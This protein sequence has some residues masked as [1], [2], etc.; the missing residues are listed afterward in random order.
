MY[1]GD[2]RTASRY[3][4]RGIETQVCSLDRKQKHNPA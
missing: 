1:T 3:V 2:N 4:S